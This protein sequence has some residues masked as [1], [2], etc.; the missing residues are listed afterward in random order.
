MLVILPLLLAC[1][2]E[3][4]VDATRLE[5]VRVAL[6][7]PGQPASLEPR[8]SAPRT[9]G[10]GSRSYTVSVGSYGVRPGFRAAA[11]LFLPAGTWSEAVLV[12]HGHY[13]EGKNSAEAQDIAH[14]LAAGGVAAL[15]VDTPG[16]EEWE[17]PGRDIHMDEG[18]HNRALL[19]AA[20]TSALALQVEVLRRGLDLLGGLGARRIA[21]TGASGGA[22]QGFWL[23]LADPRVVGVALA[24]PPPIPREA[25]P[26]GCPCDQLPGFPGPDPGV[27]GLL[28]VPSLWMSELDQPRPE[29]LRA[30]ARFEVLPGPHSYNPD[31]ITRALAWMRRELGFSLSDEEISPAPH[32]ELHTRG[33]AEDPDYRAISG[34]ELGPG[35]TW[36]VVVEEGPA[37]VE[38]CTGEGLTVLVAGGDD[39]DVAAITAAGL[40]ACTLSLLDEDESGQ[41]AALASRDAWADHLAG[42]LR[43]AAQHRQ[44]FGVYAVRAWEAP[45]FASALPYVVRDPVTTLDQ[46]DV[47]R[48]PPWIHVP[49]AWWGGLERARA[50]A[51]A[52]GQDPMALAGVLAERLH[53]TR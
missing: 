42:T 45:A 25:R 43:L 31:M 5:A 41:A 27:L 23:A 17:V 10:E 18:A 7:F 52:A 13:G 29:G 44:A 53:P 24:S 6:S 32:V 39:A 4:P 14:R 40:R 38:S 20:G 8:W 36:N 33:P 35:P 50:G 28:E 1:S 49:G 21:A 12:A 9:L 47:P 15:V 34:L 30:S 19:A 3:P 46:L 22:V 2:R 26:G 51:M 48:D 16:V 37:P 11:L